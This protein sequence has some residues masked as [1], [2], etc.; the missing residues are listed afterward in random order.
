M[1]TFLKKED[2]DDM[3]NITNHIDRND[4]NFDKIQKFDNGDHDN[5]GDNE[6]ENDDDNDDDNDNLGDSNINPI[7]SE[8]LEHSN[9]N[10]ND[11]DEMQISDNNSELSD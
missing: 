8:R 1:Q 3:H 6:N 9:H 5:D 11:D 7:R 10:D 2:S 4:T